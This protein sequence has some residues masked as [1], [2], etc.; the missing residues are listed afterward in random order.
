VQAYTGFV[1]KGFGLVNQINKGL[2]A[3]MQRDGVKN[4]SELVGQGK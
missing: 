3:L 2:V 4:I 1:Y